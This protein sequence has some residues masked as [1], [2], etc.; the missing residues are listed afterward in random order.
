[1][2][3]F[4][5]DKEGHRIFLNLSKFPKDAKIVKSA[6]MKLDKNLLSND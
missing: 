2:K 4:F 3:K 1:M 6:V 5:D